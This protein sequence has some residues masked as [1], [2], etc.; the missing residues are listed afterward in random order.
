MWIATFNGLDKFDKKTRKF[1]CYTPS[2][3]PGSLSNSSVYC[4]IKDHQGTM[5]VGTYFG[6]ANYFNPEYEIYTYYR[7]GK[8]ESEGL[9]YPVIG[10]MASGG[11]YG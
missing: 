2:D 4:I 6:G 5:W 11:I 1:T 10:C 8:N 9:T 7:P 3:V